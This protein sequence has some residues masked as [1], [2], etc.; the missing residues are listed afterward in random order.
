MKLHC[1]VKRWRLPL[2]KDQ[3]LRYT[4]QRILLITILIASSVGF[5]S[6]SWAFDKNHAYNLSMKIALINGLSQSASDD[7]WKEILEKDEGKLFDSSSLEVNLSKANVAMIVV[8]S[9][10][11]LQELPYKQLGSD[12]YRA[13]ADNAED[14]NYL[15]Q[16][17]RTEN[18]NIVYIIMYKIGS[19]SKL[20]YYC[21]ADSFISR[22]HNGNN[23]RDGESGTITWDSCKVS[24]KFQ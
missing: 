16:M 3:G 15:S 14:A 5:T 18:G 21:A 19:P 20:K 12:L 22:L 1:S 10:E 11:N 4:L 7:F 9:W 17:V 13:A 6:Q 2:N 24:K 8:K 23:L